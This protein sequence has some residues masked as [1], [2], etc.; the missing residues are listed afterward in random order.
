MHRARKRFGQHFLRDFGIIR[1][2]IN[3]LNP[4]A[5]EVIVEIGP[6]L[7]ALTL[8]LL[9]QQKKLIAIELDKD[10]IPIL[11]QRS[12]SLGSLKIYQGDV[13]NFDFTTLV[14][15]QKLRLVG[16]LPYN[17]STP[18]LFHLLQN[19]ELFIDMHFMLQLE[20][21]ERMAAEVNTA[22]Y[23]RL[24]VMLQLYFTIEKL[25]DVPPE[26]FDPPPKVNSAV[27]RLRPRTASLVEKIKNL[28]LFKELVHLAFQ[29][30]RKMLR[31]SLEKYQPDFTSLGLAPTLRAENLSLEQYIHLAN[32]LS[33]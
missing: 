17:I 27:V 21:A 28:N 16:N 15:E 19:P 11:A 9:A 24:S 7:G 5:E 18:L 29:Q 12:Q 22:A 4:Q 26:A 14:T 20:V 8:P 23:G 33:A 31:K 2:I 3:A 13:L 32:S 10:V 1:A 6:G 30:R 25:F